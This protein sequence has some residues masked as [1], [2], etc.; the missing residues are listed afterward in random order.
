M[1]EIKYSIDGKEFVFNVPKNQ[2]FISGE[3]TV[4]S[5]SETDLIYSQSWYDDGYTTLPVFTIEEYDKIYNGIS[6]TVKKIIEGIGVD[7]TGFTL[8]KYHE[9]INNDEDHF[10]IVNRTRDLFPEDFDFKI[11]NL[12]DYFEQKIGV[13]LTDRFPSTGQILHIII[14]INRPNSNDFNPPHQDVDDNN[15]DP[16]VNVWIPICGVTNDSSLCV[17]KGSH[18]ISMDK[19]LKTESGGVLGPNNYRVRMIKSWNGSNQMSRVKIKHSEVLFFT[20]FLIH[21][22]AINTNPDITRVALEFRLFK[23]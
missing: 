23:K 7:V 2:E 9:Y 8:E 5:N 20:P 3:N 18:L 14:R 13:K 17:V 4:L 10:K 19:I 11:E 12:I 6:D 22:I 21:G 16:M 1:M 15:H